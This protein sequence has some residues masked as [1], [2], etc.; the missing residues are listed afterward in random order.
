MDDARAL[1]DVLGRILDAPVDGLRPL[2]G[3]ASREIWAFSVDGRELVLRRDPATQGTAA[4]PFPGDRVAA[5]RAEAAVLEAAA[6]AGVPVPALHGHGDGGPGP[7]GSPGV[8]GPYLLME[9]LD[10]ETIPRRLLR[11]ERW[12]RARSALPGQLGQALARIHAVPVDGLPLELDDPLARL[13]EWYDGFGEPRPAI[14][15]VLRRLAVN[16]PPPVPPRLV[17]GDFRNGNLMVGE[18]GLVAVLDWE[19][20]A[21][22]D[23]V[24]DLGWLCVKAWRFGAPAPVGGFGGRDE[25]LD[26]YAEVAGWRPDPDTLHWWE[27]FGTLEWAVICRRQAERH[28]SGNE[29]SVELAVLGRRVCESEWDALLALGLASPLTVPDPLAEPDPDAGAAERP[30][31]DELLEA[32]G[33]H[34]D[35]EQSGPDAR[36][37]FHARVA[38]NALKIA[39]RE[40]RVGARHRAEHAE[41]LAALGCADDAALAAAIRAGE[42]D[43]RGDEVV[44]AVRA[45]TV[46]RLTVANPRYLAQPPA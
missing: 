13:R 12:A 37:R 18:E 7:D 39:R 22:G 29:P 10:G 1:G 36:A 30:T 11:D 15:L 5:V 27:V 2:A 21:L 44:D 19:R 26:G 33:T 34:L 23:P 4:G 25:L 43:D 9:Y 46:A 20:A 38:A 16:P 8:G 41:R 28:L 24:R 31:V 17:H 14:E 35:D 40:L 6:K 45:Q 32:A 3:G 42:L